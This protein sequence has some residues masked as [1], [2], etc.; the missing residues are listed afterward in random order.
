MVEFVAKTLLFLHLKEN[1]QVNIG[2]RKNPGILV[3]GHDLRD[4]EELLEQ[5][6]GKGVDVYTH[7]EM[8]PV[9]AYPFFKQYEQIHANTEAPKSRLRG[10]HRQFFFKKVD[11]RQ[12]F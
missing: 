5:T 7:G 10:T 8:L 9:A 4:L 2:V 1:Q 11:L 12:K 6:K 3:T